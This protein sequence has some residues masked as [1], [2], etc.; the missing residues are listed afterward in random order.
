M[1]T[2]D[3]LEDFI[4]QLTF[5][6]DNTFLTTHCTPDKY[7]CNEWKSYKDKAVEQSSQWT[8]GEHTEE[9][10]LT[11]TAHLNPIQA[12]SDGKLSM[13]S[14]LWHIMP[15]R[16]RGKTFQNQSTNVKNQIWQLKGGNLQFPLSPLNKW[17]LQA[18]ILLSKQIHTSYLE[19]EPTLRLNG[20]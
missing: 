10:K 13:I 9:V 20:I 4:I 8:V 2:S 19:L 6:K 12:T 7:T 5:P 15:L 3:Q 17:L 14:S 1:I 16:T 11:P 18:A